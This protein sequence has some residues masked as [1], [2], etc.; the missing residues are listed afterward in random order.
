MSLEKYFDPH[1]RLRLIGVL[2][3]FE[4]VKNTK[5]KQLIVK[6]VSNDTSLCTLLKSELFPSVEYSYTVRIGCHVDCR[7]R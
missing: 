4:Q 5:G 1:R 2:N 3:G 7:I 6:T